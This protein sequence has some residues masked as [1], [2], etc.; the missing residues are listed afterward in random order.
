MEELIKQVYEKKLADGT[1]EKIIDEK[2]DELIRSSVRDLFEWGGPIKKQMTAKIEGVMSEAIKQSDF[3]KYVDV[4]KVTINEMLKDSSLGA[5]RETV[6]CLKELLGNE[7]PAPKEINVSDM[8]KKF[9]EC[10]GEMKVSHDDDINND[11]ET[12]GVNCVMRVKREYG[13]SYNIT[14]TIEPYE[15]GD[16]SDIFDKSYSFSTYLGNDNYGF[17][18]FSGMS[19]KDLRKADEFTAYLFRLSAGYTHVILDERDSLE[20]TVSLE[21]EY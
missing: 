8:F 21:M 12:A 2:I 19:L 14:F 7:E 9:V 13:S 17:I 1:I 15:D 5:Y 10:V 16:E 6:L 11:G 4:F 18:D 3:D 20:E